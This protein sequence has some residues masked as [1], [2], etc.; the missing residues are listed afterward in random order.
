MDPGETIF[1]K[2]QQVSDMM[3]EL[4]GKMEKSVFKGESCDGSVRIA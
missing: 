1:E 3:D 2:A 4:R